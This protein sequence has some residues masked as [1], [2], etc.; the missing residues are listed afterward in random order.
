MYTQRGRLL[1]G[2]LVTFREV[3]NC[4]EW[5]LRF[6]WNPFGVMESQQE[7]WEDE[8]QFVFSLLIIVLS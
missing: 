7:N 8:N 2:K 6:S 5:H 4:P 1:N 3:E